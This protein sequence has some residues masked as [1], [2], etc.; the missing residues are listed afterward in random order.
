MAMCRTRAVH[1]FMCYLDIRLNSYHT[2]WGGSHDR[3]TPIRKI[4]S[5]TR[6]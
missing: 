3:V 5:K 6:G 2:I 1:M 4:E